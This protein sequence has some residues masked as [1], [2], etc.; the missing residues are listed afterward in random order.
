MQNNKLRNTTEGYMGIAK[1]FE[2]YY[3]IGRELENVG[4]RTWRETRW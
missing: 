3:T 2:E 1:S 4:K